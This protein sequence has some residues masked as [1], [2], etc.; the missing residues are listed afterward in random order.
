MKKLMTLL[1]VFLLPAISSAQ[2]DIKQVA[3]DFEIRNLGFTV[4]GTFNKTV[5]K[6]VKDTKA[7]HVSLSGQAF[8]KSINTGNHQRD[9]DLQEDK[10]FNETEYPQITVETS[11][12]ELSGNYQKDISLRVTIKGVLKNI[13]GTLQLKSTATTKKIQIN[14]KLNRQDFNV[15]GSSFLMSKDVTVQVS[16]MVNN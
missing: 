10:Y 7:S 1:L 4:N 8:T 5:V 11:A 13:P 2:E 15:G 9:S 3:V 6:I 14:F 12:F 16:A